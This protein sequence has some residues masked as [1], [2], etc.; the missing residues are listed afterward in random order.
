[1]KKTITWF[2]ENHVAAN[3][4]MIFVLIA[5]FLT[6]FNAKVEIFPE[7]A[8]DKV[9]VTIMYPGAS[10]AEVEEGVVKKVEEAVSGLDGIKEI[11]AYASEGAAVIEVEAIEGWDIDQLF[12]DV[13]AEVNRITTLPENAE[14]PVIKKFVFK[15]PVLNVAVYGDAPV[16]VLKDYAEKIKDDIT[17]LPHVTQAEVFGVSDPE[18]AIEISEENLRKYGLT[19]TRVADIVRK[20]SLDIGGGE[21]KE[22]S[23]YILLRVKGRKYMASEYRDVVVLS[24]PDGTEIKLSDIATIRDTFEEGEKGSRFDEKPSVGILVYRI[25]DENA[26]TVAKEVKGYIESIKDSLPPG[27]H[28]ETF[29]D[30]SEIL[31]ARLSLLLKNM[32]YGMV[33]VVIVLGIFLNRRL[34]FWITLGIPIAFAAGLILLPHYDVSINMVSLFAF[35]MVLGIV[36]DDA[37]VV[38]EGIFR[39]REEGLP[40]FQAAVEGTLEMAVPVIFAVLTTVAAFWPL[41]LGTGVMGK[42]I[43]NIPV[44][45]IAVLM[46]SLIEALLIL[47][48]HLARSRL[49]AKR[50]R[51]EN[52]VSSCMNGFING[53]FR[54]LLALSLKW[55]YVTIAAGV[56][57]LLVSLG[58]WFGGRIKFTFFPKVESDRMVCEVT[59]PPGTPYS[60]TLEVIARVE[61]MAIEAASEADRLR[62]DPEEPLIRYT[63]SILGSQIPMGHRSTTGPLPSGSHVGQVIVQLIGA[64]KRKGLTTTEVSN[65]WRKKVGTIP[66]AE[67][68]RF[69]SELF[70][71]GKSI[72]FDLTMDD[73]T[74]LHR[75][76]EDLKRELGNYPGVYDIEDS[77]IPGKEEI[78]LALRPSARSLGITLSDLA[79][80]VRAAFY[81][82]EALRLQRGVDEVKVM[83]RYPKEE[84]RRLESLLE[85]YIR[86]P[87]GRE[88]PFSEVATLKKTRSY[89]SIIRRDRKRIV[90]VAADVDETVMNA[91]ELR[92]EMIQ[93]I[94]PVLQERYPGLKYSI[95]GEGKEQKESMSDVMRGFFLA[96]ILIYTLIAIPLRSFGQPLVIMSAIPFGIIGA[97]FGHMLMGM[98]LSIMSLFGVV[99]LSGVVVNDSLI[100]FVAINRLRT[101]GLPTFEAILRGTAG[102]FRP[103]ILTTLTTFA[104]LIPII[105][106]QSVQAKFLIPMALSLAFGVLFAT[107]ITLVLVPCG[108]QVMED[109]KGMLGKKEN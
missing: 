68:V 66:G 24:R 103:V 26:L 36:V 108:Y 39:K 33:L 90:T 51:K 86:T 106:E 3:L 4:L 70:S 94:M 101:S 22:S 83:V 109:L 31:K 61:E 56:G 98:N 41:S 27:I 74:A 85:M 19:L 42:V 43:K 6:A 81:G 53:P 72:S 55:R 96:I 73:E 21:I 46:G 45:V 62:K 75:A 59:M 91:N 100:L 65:I 77:Y 10:P 9:S 95:A 54:K 1:M 5:G 87:D 17:R 38:G 92:G 28:A 99:G 63:F 89:V 67:S 30:R 79:R 60:K 18:I 32:A 105:T 2:T 78:R 12:D 69:Y 35:I 40:P 15:A 104:G 82:A 93:K 25:G 11:N 37:I 7:T 14:R 20:W 13:K 8:A 71:A 52:F 16:H 29:G 48:A 76:V 84:R 47:P 88:I 64:E 102:R 44:V 34:S 57:I 49:P 23:G 97:I 80:Q 58:L 50:G 107:I